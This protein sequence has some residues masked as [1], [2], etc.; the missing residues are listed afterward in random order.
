MAIDPSKALFTRDFFFEVMKDSQRLRAGY[1]ADRERW[2]R[3]L[4]LDGREEILFEFEMLMRGLERYFNVHNLPLDGRQNLMGRDFRGELR[5]VR[6]AV[7]RTV[8]L[9]QFLLDPP[10][11]R[12]LV[13]RKYLESQIVDDRARGELLEQQLTQ[14][15]P[16]ESLFLIRSGMTALRGVMDGL[17][18]LPQVSY[19]LFS[20]LGQVLV[21]EIAL[22]KYFRPFRPLEFRSEYDRIKSVHILEILGRMQ[23][24]GEPLRKSISLAFLALFRLLHYLRYIPTTP[25]EP[26]R[27][28]YL[29]MSL[30]SSEATALASYLERGLQRE[31]V[32]QP[33][34]AA[35][36]GRM[37]VE[38]RKEVGKVLRKHL[39]SAAPG[40]AEPIAK[41]REALDSLFKQWVASLA[42][43]FEPEL[44]GRELFDDYVSR[45]EQAKRLRADLWC[46]REV[47]HRAEQRAAKGEP[48]E[49]E[50]AVKELR[51]FLA[52]FRDV[53]YQLLRYADYEPFDGFISIVGELDT[54][55]AKQPRLRR[56]LR[57]DLRSFGD[58]LNK[59]FGAVSKREELS[60]SPFD[61]KEGR[62]ILKQLELDLVA[63]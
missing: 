16:Q 9:T 10:S 1:L 19:Q 36:A 38:I 27:R 55:K 51:R 29:V 39:A 6:D 22:N 5:A 34:A 43:A 60:G 40:D 7:G 31:L 21:R 17:L 45:R 28:G 42:Q 23:A 4:A 52:Y 63:S 24:Q 33:A 53:S 46:F 32:A 54:G 11:D 14:E 59:I 41:A 56:Q 26:A 2:L 25:G 3:E 13:F 30:V 49:M 18:R 62:K 58:V 8:H 37:A 47:C 61:Q 15:T 44:Q 35:V 57:D 48:D 12:N 50:R 20:D